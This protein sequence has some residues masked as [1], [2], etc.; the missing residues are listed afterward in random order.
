MALGR[1]NAAKFIARLLPEPHERDL[2]GEPAHHLLA[3]A[4]AD[5]VCPPA[6]H[7]IGWDDCYASAKMLPLPRKA[8]LL[9]RSDGEPAPVPEH[10]TG[11][12]RERAEYAAQLAAWIRRE[13]HRRGIL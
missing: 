11:E 10:L 13:A 3:T 5:G 8:D 4:H 9:L 7:S 2:G 12:A 1:V 6:G